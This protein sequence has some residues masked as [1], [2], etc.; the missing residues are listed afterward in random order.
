MPLVMLLAVP[1]VRDPLG[2]VF[3]DFPANNVEFDDVY[4]VDDKDTECLR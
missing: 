4:S 3:G 1:L 2:N